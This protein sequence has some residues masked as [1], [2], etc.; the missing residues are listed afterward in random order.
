[1]TDYPT[2][3]A[4]VMTDYLTAPAETQALARQVADLR[5]EAETLRAVLMLM[6]EDRGEARAELARLRRACV[7][8]D[9]PATEAIGMLRRVPATATAGRLA[10]ALTALRE[11]LG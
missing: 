11:A 6:T 5:Q 4:I 7:E 9:L 8:I 3:E 10:Q 1:M 2:R